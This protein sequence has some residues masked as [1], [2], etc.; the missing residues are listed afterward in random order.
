MPPKTDNNQTE[1]SEDSVSREFID[2]NNKKKWK[3]NKKIILEQWIEPIQYVLVTL[4]YL[5]DCLKEKEGT[6]DGGLY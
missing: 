3:D 2:P 4:Q 1:R 5:N 6:V